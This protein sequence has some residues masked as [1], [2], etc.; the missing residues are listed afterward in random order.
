MNF[1]GK[2]KNRLIQYD[3]NIGP[4]DEGVMEGLQ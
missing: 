1:E 4:M 3:M 2:A